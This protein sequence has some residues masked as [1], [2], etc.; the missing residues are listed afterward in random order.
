V[1]GLTAEPSLYLFVGTTGPAGNERADMTSFSW[2]PDMARLA[3]ARNDEFGDPE[4]RVADLAQG[5]I[6]TIGPGDA[7]DWAP[8]GR[9]IACS[10]TVPGAGLG[11]S[12]IETVLPDGS[13]RTTLVSLT[14]RAGGGRQRYARNPKWSP[15][16]GYLAYN[17]VYFEGPTAT[18]FV[19]RV[20]ASGTGDTNLTPEVKTPS[21]GTY[22]S[23]ALLI[24]WR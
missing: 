12:V 5:T 10:R 2:S 9:K 13:G 4:L 11:K 17:D 20:S 1:A 8:D 14:I 22:F 19:R 3:F 21:S 24:D 6:T 7:P 23:G 18:Y 16:G 15:D